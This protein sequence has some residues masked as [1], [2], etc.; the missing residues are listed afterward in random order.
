MPGRYTGRLLCRAL[1]H[2]GGLRY[3]T[4]KNGVK[5]FVVWS[6]SAVDGNGLFPYRWCGTV[7][8]CPSKFGRYPGDP[9]S[10]TGRREDLLGRSLPALADA[11][12]GGCQC[13]PPR[14]AHRLRDGTGGEGKRPHPSLHQVFG[15]ARA[16]G[17]ALAA[18]PR[19]T[20]GAVP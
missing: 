20:Q 10:L 12:P 6:F 19:R 5:D 18:P 9:P 2:G 14:S 11:D 13:I 7:G 1:W 8:S 17:R 16:P 4:E 15:D 3:M